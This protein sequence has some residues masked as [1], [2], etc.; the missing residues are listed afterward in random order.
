MGIFGR[1][2][3]PSEE[4]EWEYTGSG[5]RMKRKIDEPVKKLRRKETLETLKRRKREE[6]EERKMAKLKQKTQLMSTK[7][8]YYE[9]KARKKKVKREASFQ[10]PVLQTKR[11]KVRKK[12]QGRKLSRK[13][14]IRLI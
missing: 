12:K 1:K 10:W 4:I 3:R 7:A 6:A 13:G 11:V 8:G 5:A 14:R 2:R 9:A